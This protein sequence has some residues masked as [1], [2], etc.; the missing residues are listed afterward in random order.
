MSNQAP[1]G[2]TPPAKKKGASRFVT[3]I[4]ALVVALGIGIFGG[5]LIGHSTATAAPRMT[6]KVQ[7]VS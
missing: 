2:T 4:L 3:P 6:L 7:A 5:V 1:A